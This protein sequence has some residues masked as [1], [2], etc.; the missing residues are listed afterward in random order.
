M[1]VQE[2]LLQERID[3]YLSD[4]ALGALAERAVGVSTVR[5]YEVLTGGCWNRVIAVDIGDRSLVYKISPHANDP[6]I[7]REFQ[8]LSVF[9]EQTS[10]AVPEPLALDST[11]TTLPG[12]VLVMSRIPGAVLH[13]CYGLLN[14][15]ARRAVTD[16]IASDLA[17]L[18]RIESVGFGGVELDES[19]RLAEWP[20]F[21][22]PR[23]DA[24][25]DDA[26]ESGAV[27]ASILDGARELRPSL[28]RP[29]SIGATST[30]THYDI[31]SGNVMVDLDRDVPR[32]SGY[33]DVP[34]FYADYARELSFAMLF[35]IANRR[36]FE[37]YL[38][39]HEL[40]PG[41][42]LRA[43]IYNLKMNIKHIG[44]YP[45]QRV[46][47]QGAVENLEFIRRVV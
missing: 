35:G 24:V 17:E 37:T 10:L 36:F 27:P 40:D 9:A 7:I 2:R 15:G 29:L 4:R 20:D 47:Q 13:E 31:W 1:N 23:F 28:A 45:T 42:E 12:T 34:G 30:M 26:A 44:M 19:Q 14:Y 33:I 25:L 41:F 8:V 11:G 21:W 39:E 16:Q 22:L 43:N 46:Y 5:G 3:P 6:K 32:V 18:H 38:A